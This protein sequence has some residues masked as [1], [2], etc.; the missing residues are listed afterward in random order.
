MHYSEFHLSAPHGLRLFGRQ[1]QP[2]QRAQIKAI[3]CLIHGIGDHSGRY[4]ELVSYL[5]NRNF[6]VLAI[7]QMG[8]GQS[9]GQRGHAG[10]YDELLDNIALL[11]GK[12]QA[13][14]PGLPIFLYGH[15]WGGNQV[16]N[17]ALRRRP[18]LQGVIA[19][20]PWLR[21]GFTPP[22]WKEWLGRLMS[23][24]YPS[25]S[26][27]S[28]LIAD[29]ISR[30]KAVVAAYLSD[31]L[32]HNKISA[33]M[34]VHSHAAGLWALE[35]AAEFPLPLLLIHGSQDTLTSPQGSQE[36]AEKNKDKV[37]FRL[38]DGM[39]H[40]THHEIGK[41]EVFKTITEW[42]EKQLGATPGL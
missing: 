30:D 17:F 6:A 25:L 27:P 22:R 39:Y 10:R 11:I 35:Q 36:F 42:M 41:E 2:E 4:Q 38:F 14:D 9:E 8:H 1:W 33:S 31:P 7:D 3:V 32:V 5:V 13:D 26:Q 16:L 18:V 19:T 23:S 40:E 12:A 34:F 29:H 15:S 37:S 28:G 24:V 21:L 20:S